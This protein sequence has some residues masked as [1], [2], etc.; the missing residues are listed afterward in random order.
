MLERFRV[1]GSHGISSSIALVCVQF[2]WSQNSC[3]YFVSMPWCRQRVS[4]L[5]RPQLVRRLRTRDDSDRLPD[6]ATKYV[7]GFC[8]MLRGA[9]RP[10]CPTALSWTLRE[11]LTALR[12]LPGLIAPRCVNSYVST[13]HFVRLAAMPQWLCARCLAGVFD[14]VIDRGRCYRAVNTFAILQGRVTQ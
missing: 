1:S 9:L 8:A 7:S 13:S 12:C 3:V 10:E 4:L 5:A 2:T 14:S 11:C 6:N